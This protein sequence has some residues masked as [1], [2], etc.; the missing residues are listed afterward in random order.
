MWFRLRA[1]LA[2]RLLTLAQR[3]APNVD[4]KLHIAIAKSRV[5]LVAHNKRY[6][7]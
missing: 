1:R 7:R 3:A 5:R 4:M 6:P 2:I